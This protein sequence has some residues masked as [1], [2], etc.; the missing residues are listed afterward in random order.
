MVSTQVGKVG[1][2]SVERYVVGKVGIWSV[3]G[4]G[5][6]FLVVKNVGKTT[7]QRYID[8]IFT[9]SENFVSQ[10]VVIFN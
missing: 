1:F 3:G 9:K 10:M 8:V 5:G 7:G 4:V 6:R 2:W